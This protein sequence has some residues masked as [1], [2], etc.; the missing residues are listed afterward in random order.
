MTSLDLRIRFCDE[1]LFVEGDLSLEMEVSNVEFSLSQLMKM[2]SLSGNNG[3]ITYETSEVQ[4]P[5][6]YPCYLYKCSG[7]NGIKE[8]SFKYRGTVDVWMNIISP[9]LKAISC[10]SAWY[11]TLR[12]IEIEDVTIVC[13]E[14][15]DHIV[16]KGNLNRDTNEWTYGDGVHDTYNIIAIDD[17]VYHKF[18]CDDCTVHYCSSD[19]EEI[20]RK[21]APSIQSILEYYNGNLFSHRELDRCD[22]VSF[23]K[24][25]EQEGAYKRADLI[26]FGQLSDD[27]DFMSW[28]MGHE[29]A[30]EW[31][32]GADCGTYHDWMNETTAEWAAFLYMIL[33]EDNEEFVTN[34]LEYHRKEAEGAPPIK[35]TDGSR[36]AEGVHNK[37]TLLFYKVYKKYGSD[38]IVELLRI[39]VEVED[40]T[41]DSYIAALRTYNDDIADMIE[42]GLVE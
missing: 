2:E 41:T 34:R 9:E 35:T 36:P 38:A 1:E 31:C 27:S 12:D 20:I 28:F 10:Y 25:G 30:H 24:I 17:S 8:V 3:K 42:M 40:K 11:P 18:E 22:I 5:F 37:G 21:T 6:Q 23:S 33:C 39:F 26:V 14:M 13:M 15:S 32:T 29:L 16:I 7:L 19:E 4:L